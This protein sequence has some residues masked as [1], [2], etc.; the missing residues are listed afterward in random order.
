MSELKHLAP[1]E[2]RLALLKQWYAE[3]RLVNTPY[4]SAWIAKEPELGEYAWGDPIRVYVRGLPE[5]YFPSAI[6]I[7]LTLGE[8]S[9]Y[10]RIEMLFFRQRLEARIHS[11]LESVR[12]QLGALRRD[13]S[14][15]IECLYAA[16][17]AYDYPT[18]LRA[19]SCEFDFAKLGKA[20]VAL[21]D[22]ATMMQILLVEGAANLEAKRREGAARD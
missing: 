3:H 2:E 8:Q 6:V 15:L 7:A 22:A 13:L 12:D 19:G 20:T 18:I 4:G 11:R 14:K 5:E 16:K 21:L 1:P 17:V 9:D 10:V